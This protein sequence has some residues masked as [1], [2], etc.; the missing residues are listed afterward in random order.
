MFWG[1]LNEKEIQKR[2][3]M[4]IHVS[5]SLCCTEEFK[6]LKQLYSNN[7]FK[8]YENIFTKANCTKEI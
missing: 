6:K 8:I 4:C 1:D 5:D 7:V 2:G 3:D